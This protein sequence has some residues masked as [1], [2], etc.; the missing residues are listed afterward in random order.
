MN[1]RFYSGVTPKERQKING[2]QRYTTTPYILTE[3]VID[4]VVC[5]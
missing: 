2:N 4:I 1:D 3:K 5:V